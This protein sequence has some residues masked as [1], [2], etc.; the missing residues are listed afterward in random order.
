MKITIPN[1]LSLLRMGLVPVFILVAIN[2]QP[3]KAL[4]VF[5]L[6]GITDALDG[7]IAR[8]WGQ[9]SLLGTYLD[10]I[11][12]KLLLMTAFVVLAIPG[13]HPG[14][15]IPL[16][17][18]V[19][20]L[21]RDVFIVIMALVLHLAAGIKSFPPTL[22]SKLTTLV[23]VLTVLLVLAA[24]LA[25][26]FETA[27]LVAVHVTALLTLVSGLYYGWR[28]VHMTGAPGRAPSAGR[29]P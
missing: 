27:S 21:A 5:L 25:P 20:V 6:A 8:V 16:W 3:G 11:A 14:P 9:Q 10:P 24:G 1:L 29:R 2:G 13:Q 18:A 12:D 4:G 22:V 23:Q 7:F 15:P 17:V 19:L 28:A 26:S